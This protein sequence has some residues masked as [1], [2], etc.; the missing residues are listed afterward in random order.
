MFKK[1]RVNRWLFNWMTRSLI[2]ME[3]ATT[4]EERNSAYKGALLGVEITLMDYPELEDYVNQLWN[5]FYRPAFDAE[6]A[7]NG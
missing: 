3:R 5:V 4:A 7:K 1:I 2:A 6:M